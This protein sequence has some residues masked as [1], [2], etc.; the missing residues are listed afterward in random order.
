MESR[1]TR[2]SFSLWTKFMMSSL[3]GLSI[4]LLVLNLLLYFFTWPY[5]TI[6]QALG[7]LAGMGVNFMFSNFFVFSKN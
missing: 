2:P 4:N 5:N 7:I 1:G 3:F 6:P